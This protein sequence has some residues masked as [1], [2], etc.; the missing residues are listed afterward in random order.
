M[1]LSKR[2][3]PEFLLKHISF[4][5]WLVA[6]STEA[7][8]PYSSIRR[9]ASA[10]PLIAVV[11]QRRLPQ[12]TGLECP[13]PGTAADHRTF[14]FAGTSHVVAVGNPSAI[15]APRMPRNDGQSTPGFGSLSGAA[16]TAMTTRAQETPIASR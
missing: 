5:V 3:W 14:F 6:S 12:M 7:M 4:Q 8:S 10:L 9:P 13:S 15:P 11:M 1:Y 2:R 16:E